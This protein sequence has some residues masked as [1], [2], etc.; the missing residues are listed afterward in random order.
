L[1]TILTL[2][3]AQ[4]GPDRVPS[5]VWRTLLAWVPML[6][7]IGVWMF[8]MKRYGRDLRKRRGPSGWCCPHGHPVSDAARTCEHC[9]IPLA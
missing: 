3:L 7:L 2:L 6:L 5:T 9:G 4:A 8:Y 1:S